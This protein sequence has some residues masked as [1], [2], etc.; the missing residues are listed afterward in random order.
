MSEIEAKKIVKKYAEKLKKEKY[1][2]SAIYLFGSY[3][4]GKANKDSDIDVAVI[5]DK[6]KKNWNRNEDMLWEYT[7]DIDS[8]IEPIGFTKEEFKNKFDPMIK[9]IRE[10]GIRVV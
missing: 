6:L 2:F 9:E 7:I 8:R 10:K 3:S 4:L 1:P 5:S